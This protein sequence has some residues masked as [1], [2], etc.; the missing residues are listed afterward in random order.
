MLEGAGSLSVAD[1]AALEAELDG[2]E[3]GSYGCTVV[4]WWSTVGEVTAEDMHSPV[5]AP[6]AEAVSEGSPDEVAWVV[7]VPAVVAPVVA[8]PVASAPSAGNAPADVR[9]APN[10]PRRKTTTIP[11]RNLL[12]A[13][14]IICALGLV[15]FQASRILLVSD[16]SDGTDEV[17]KP[18][19]VSDTRVPTRS[20]S[21][22][23]EAGA[24]GVV[25]TT[26]STDRPDLVA[27]TVVVPSS[28][29]APSTARTSVPTSTG[30]TTVASPSTTAPAATKR[31]AT[32]PSPSRS[33]TTSAS[34][35]TTAT[36]LAR[37]SVTA[38]KT[39]VAATATAAAAGGD[40]S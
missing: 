8:A 40:R 31:T 32:T 17:P 23:S 36:P 33:S 38:T 28:T 4:T 37:P 15:G 11:R 6:V 5:V 24:P 25:T 22:S 18:L 19:P 14:V 9:R 2:A 3:S 16:D 12:V 35:T 34:S 7:P 10:P 27:A 29:S 21:P 39:V 1:R 13:A 20:T 30:P 26:A